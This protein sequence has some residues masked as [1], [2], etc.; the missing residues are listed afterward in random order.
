[1]KRFFLSCVC[2]ALGLSQAGAFVADIN[3]Q[4]FARRWN[5]ATYDGSVHTNVVNFAT[6]AVRF[7]LASDAYSTENRPYELAALR[8]SFAEWHQA[9]GSTLKFE[10]AGLVAPGVDV[11]TMDN[12]NVVFWVK[13]ES[14][15]GHVYV[16]GGR[17]D[18]SGALAVAFWDAYLEDNTIVECDIVFNSFVRVN[19]KLC[20]WSAEYQ[21]TG[22]NF[23]IEGIMVHEVGHMLGL[24][25]S[26]VG[27][28]CMMARAESGSPR[29]AGLSSDELAGV[30]FLYGT[31]ILA[32]TLGRVQGTVTQGGSAVLGAVVM[33]EDALGNTVQGTLTRSN[34]V[35]ELAALAPGNYKIRVSPMDPASPLPLMWGGDISPAYYT[36]NT[37]FLPTE[38]VEVRVAA[39]QQAVQDVAVAGVA[40]AWRINRVREQTANANLYT[41]QN[42]PA[43]LVAGQSNLWVGVAGYGLPTEGASLSITG[44]GLTLGSPVYKPNI[45]YGQGFNV[46]TVSISVSSN[47]TPG[48]RT[49]ILKQGANIAYANGFVDILPP[50]PDANH[51][52][53]D[54]RWQA[55]YFGSYSAASAQVGVDFDRDGLSNLSEYLAATNPTNTASCLRMDSV[56]SQAGVTRLSWQSVAGRSYQVYSRDALSGANGWQAV[57][58]AVSASSS[59]TV[60]YDPNTPGARRFYRVMVYP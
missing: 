57:G 46:I 4:G 28:A 30:R 36:A 44:D 37:G 47:A 55:Q 52:Q 21:P 12:T 7:H 49:L 60:W 23:S 13:S 3:P 56:S 8:A 59:N 9:G 16:N 58:S 17:D 27:A 26:P 15:G 51:D 6:H 2:A 14:E 1:M 20:G 48:M 40:P 18:I 11:N 29:L 43:T 22:N 25:H 53:I 45:I 50:N 19:G 34:G 41:V 5:L 54:D 24:G 31:A 38:P 32:S 39:G 35:Y 10:D 33:A 42:T